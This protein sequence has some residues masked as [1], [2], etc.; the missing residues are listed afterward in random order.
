MKKLQLLNMQYL[1]ADSKMIQHAKQQNFIQQTYKNY[2]YS[3]YEVFFKA[4]KKDG[5]LKVSVFFTHHLQFG[6]TEP[7]YEIYLDKQEQKFMTYIPVQKK[8]SKAKIDHFECSEGIS[9]DKAF[10]SPED[11]KCIQEYLESDQSVYYSILSF[12]MHILESRLEKKH[13]KVTDVWAKRMEQ[14]PELPKDWNRWLYK[15]GVTQHFIFYQYNRKR[16]KEGYCTWCEKKVEITVPK[17]NKMGRCPCCGHKIQFKAIGRCKR[18]QTEEETAYLIQKCKE[19]FVVREFQTIVTYLIGSTKPVC[20]SRETRRIL[21]DRDLNATEFY[22]GDYK[23]R[24]KNVWIEGVLTWYLGIYNMGTQLYNAGKVYGRTL[25]SLAKKELRNTGFREWL[26]EIGVVSPKYYFQKLKVYPYL[27]KLIK[28]GLFNLAEEIMDRRNEIEF[29]DGKELGKALGIDHFRMKRLRENKGGIVYLEWLIKEKKENRIIDDSVLRWLDKVNLKPDELQFI[30]DRMSEKQIKNYVERQLQGK[31]KNVQSL[32]YLWEDYLSMAKRVGFNVNDPIVYRVKDLKKRH[33]E[34]LQIVEDKELAL[35]AADI[36]K[37]FPEI[38]TICKEIKEKYEYEGKEY[39]IV[40][41][42]KIEDIL[43]EGEVLH[44]C[45]DKNNNYFERISKRETYILFLRRKKAPDVPYYT[46]EV[47]P[48]GSIRQKRTEFNRQHS[49]LKQA[50]SFLDRWQEQLQKKLTVED[51]ALA[52]ESKKAR[53]RE[54]EELR[55]KKIKING[56]DYAGQLL[57][58]VL[59]ADLMEVNAA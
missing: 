3:P 34:M 27:E 23:R 36:E 8:W 15:V 56:G 30:S 32:L 52:V 35:K 49:D 54:L 2:R 47:E 50:E 26:K 44:H 57:A 33:D 22:Y 13:R 24:G 18:V 48:G 41:P 59:A 40:A 9:F 25:P 10:C 28:A 20:H 11:T 14:V 12:Q 17:H 58:D 21:Y 45:I 51:L 5:I 37:E 7:V 53:K 55:T 31:N 42:S 16:K 43:T 46:L 6:A 39:V 1:S 38:D 29:E 19:G 4:Y